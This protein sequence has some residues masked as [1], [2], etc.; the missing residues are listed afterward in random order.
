M[1]RIR[2]D[3]AQAA[4]TESALGT[5][6]GVETRDGNRFRKSDKEKDKNSRDNDRFR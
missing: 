4:M 2:K 3:Q 5:D 6:S 1:F